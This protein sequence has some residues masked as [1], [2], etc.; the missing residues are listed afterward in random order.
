MLGPMGGPL[1]IRL[2]NEAGQ[3]LIEYALLAGLIA[4]VAVSSVTA[5][6]TLVKDTFWAVIAAAIP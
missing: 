6:G 3:D 2:G 4:M 1:R 5:L